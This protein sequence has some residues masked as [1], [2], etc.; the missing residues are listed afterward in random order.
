MTPLPIGQP[1]FVTI[2]EALAWHDVSIAQYGGSYG[3]R[4]RGALESALAQPRQRFGD[5]YA[6]TYP[7]R[8]ATAY[9]Y[10]I[11]KNHPFVDGNKRTALMCCGGFLRMN[12][13]NLTS[14]GEQAADSILALVTDEIS[15]ADFANWLET[16]SRKRPS[17]ELRDFFTLID[18]EAFVDRL[19]AFAA[20]QSDADV[21]RSTDEAGQAIPLLRA[22]DELAQSGTGEPGQ[23][24]LQGAIIA[25]TALYRIAEDMGYEW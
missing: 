25:L 11:T 3:I 6:H 17:M 15:R 2:E 18:L 21:H 16:H 10:F 4:D 7:F 14:D 20:N 12:G 8:M 22:L 23:A 19:S 13:W 5:E 24:G 9:A 1:R